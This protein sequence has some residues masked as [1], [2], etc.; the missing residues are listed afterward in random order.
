MKD[1]VKAMRWGLPSKVPAQP[2]D[3]A[4]EKAAESCMRNISKAEVTRRY[5]TSAAGA[6][7]MTGI[8]A[9]LLR[10]GIT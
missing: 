2:F 8:T 3:V 4:E 5:Y 9:F 6:L 10:A 7:L 1:S